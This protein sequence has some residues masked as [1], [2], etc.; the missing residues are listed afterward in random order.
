MLSSLQWLADKLL[1]RQERRRADLKERRDRVAA[2]FD[3]L[4]DT[5]SSMLSSFKEGK[6]PRVEGH[7][8]D[9]LLANF[10]SV[11]RSIY[12]ENIETEKEKVDRMLSGLYETAARARHIDYEMLA[13][14]HL[15][16]S[17]QDGTMPSR[18]EFLKDLER[19]IGTYQGLARSLRA[20][21]IE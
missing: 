5:L 6:I 7:R 3:S 16:E 4:A 1:Q 2:F 17:A 11:V 21:P 8:L 12:D 18:E 19:T 15:S 9:T 13:I 14:G 10:D 20:S